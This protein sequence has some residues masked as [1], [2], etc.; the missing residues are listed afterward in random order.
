MPFD[1]IP[2]A[3]NSV[4]EITPG[5]NALALSPDARCAG[6]VEQAYAFFAELGPLVSDLGSAMRTGVAAGTAWKPNP[7]IAGFGVKLAGATGYYAAVGHQ[8]RPWSRECLFVYGASGRQAIS[9]VTDTP[10]SGSNDRS[11]FVDAASKLAANLYD[12]ALK[13][14][15][16]A[17]TLIAGR[18]YHAV[19]T[20][21]STLLSVYLDGVLEGTVAIANAGLQNYTAP[22]LVFGYGLRGAGAASTTNT[23]F[24]SVEYNQVLSADDVRHRY[25]NQ[26]EMFRIADVHVGGSVLIHMLKSIAWHIKGR[27]TKPTAWHVAAQTMKVTAWRV[28]TRAGKSTSWRIFTRSAKT[29][30]WRILARSGKTTA[31]RVFTRASK[32]ASWR[33]Y[34]RAAKATAWSILNTLQASKATAWRV[35][36]RAQKPSAWRIFT[37]ASKSVSWRVMGRRVAASIWRVFTR[38]VKPSAWRIGPDPGAAADVHLTAR[39]HARKITA[40]PHRRSILAK[41]P[42]R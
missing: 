32:S 40:A 17:T 41:S 4:A 23:L 24:W 30:A 9:T 21:S 39:P 25:L 5:V 13:T 16:G 37:R 38:L 3:L 11:L 34:G 6:F 33:V 18:A 35:M 7:T 28:V 42:K 15:T 12:G 27:A 8:L 22:K 2:Y 26:M 19:V 14:A 36:G 29:T 20:A 31:W 10:G 1:A